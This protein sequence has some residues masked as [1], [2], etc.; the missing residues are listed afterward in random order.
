MNISILTLDKLQNDL[1]F[2]DTK[3]VGIFFDFS[4][5]RENLHDNKQFGRQVWQQPYLFYFN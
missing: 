3:F 1:N 2:K 4:N 5:C